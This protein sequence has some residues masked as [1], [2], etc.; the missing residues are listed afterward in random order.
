MVRLELDKLKSMGWGNYLVCMMMHPLAGG[1]DG[2]AEDGEDE[3]VIKKRGCS[4][5][6]KHSG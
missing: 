6:W 3:R 2:G 5:H 4:G 1:V